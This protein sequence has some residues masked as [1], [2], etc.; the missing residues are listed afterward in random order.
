MFEIKKALYIVPT[1]IGNMDDITVRACEVLKLVDYICAEDTRHS[2]PLLEG[3]G[4]SSPKLISYHDHNE[5]E[6]AEKIILFPLFERNFP[7]SIFR[8]E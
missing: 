6:K 4:V 3:I 1:P 7:S 5:T 2:L 8:L